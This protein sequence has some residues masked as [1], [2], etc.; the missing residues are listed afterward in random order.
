MTGLDQLAFGNVRPENYRRYWAHLILAI[1]VVSYS[2]YV[3]HDELRSYIRLRQ[4]YLTSPQHRLRASATTVLVSA[5]PRKWLT[6]D[7][8]DGLYDVFPGGI[9]NIWINRN[10]DA[11]SEKVHQRNKL[12]RALEAAQTDLIRNAK[13]A[14]IK[15]EQRAAKMAGQKMGATEK[16]RQQEQNEVEGRRLAEQ[17]GKSAGDP[18]QVR[19]TLLEAFRRDRHPTV[20]PNEGA[21]RFRGPIPILGHGLQAVGHGVGAVSNTVFG[22]FKRSGKEIEERFTTAPGFVPTAGIPETSSPSRPVDKAE[23]SHNGA[24]DARPPKELAGSGVLQP[25]DLH[26]LTVPQVDG[27]GDRRGF[28]PR[29]SEPLE[30]EPDNSGKAPD[31][32]EEGWMSWAGAQHENQYE[33]PSPQPTTKAGAGRF[34]DDQPLTDLSPSTPHAATGDYETDRAKASAGTWSWVPFMGT[35]QEEKKVEYPPAFSEDADEDEGEPEWRKYLKPAERDYMR[36]P[37]FGWEWM[38]ALPLI[39]KKVDTILYC[40]KE[41]AR[42]NVEIERDQQNPEDFPLMNSAFVQFN[43]QVAAHMACQSVSHHVPKQMAPRI[44]EIS[45]DDVL[46]DNM[47]IRWWESYIRTILVVAFVGGLIVLWAVP[48]AFTGTLSSIDTLTKTVKWLDW[49]NRL[50]SWLLS[51]VQGVLPQALLAGLLAL[52]PLIL[53]FLA[54]Q[55]GVQTGMG[56]ELSVQTYFF[57][58]L[59]IQVFL[60]V[61]IST[62]IT[63]T[64]Q[65]LLHN[66]SNVAGILAKN[67]PRATNYFF[68]YMILQAFSVSGG[69]LL[70]I[71]ALISWFILAPVLD[72]TARQKWARQTDLP[73]MR[74]GTFFP[75]Y[76]NLAAIGNLFLLRITPD[77]RLTLRNRVGV[78]C[79]LSSHHGLQYYHIRSLLDRLQVQHPLRYQ[80]SIRHRRSP[81]P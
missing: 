44:V 11:L 35:H 77:H 53:R 48:V 52:L 50:P 3:F 26:Q 76:T 19:H 28:E 78:L 4:A 69:A 22:G 18:H 16:R 15:Q 17:D 59:F 79:H 36:L 56:V 27:L 46:W 31:S 38:P 9:R 25:H 37:I 51:L 14:Q 72:N 29:L 13:K 54:K 23:I 49:L 70:Q 12:A 34:N 20:A 39:G 73:V 80:I 71:G 62:G 67:L 74:W 33:L 64:L 6:I 65:E 57:A 40:R 42:L 8:L 61:S 66:P 32:A 43:H 63:A 58:F 2:C 5:I 55:Q 30:G 1:I 68:S 60:V 45:P 24:T 41:V 75:V 21:G 7:A 81:L 47:S 10:F